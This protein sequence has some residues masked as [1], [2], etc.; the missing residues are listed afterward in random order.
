MKEVLIVSADDILLYQPTLLNLYDYLS[1]TFA[2]RIISFEPEFLGTQKEESRNIIYLSTTKWKKRILRYAELIINAPLKR[3]DKYLFKLPFRVQYV[4]NYKFHLL[5]KELKKHH[6]DQVISVDFM[7]LVAVQKIL[8]NAHLLSLEILSYDP[9][10]KRAEVPK[11]KSLL[12]QN[13]LR[14]NYLFPKEK[15]RVFYIQNSPSC[16]NSHFN[17]G[18]REGLVWGG[19]IAKMFGVFHCIEFIKTNP[20]FSLVLKGGAPANVL[21]EI[22]SA[23]GDLI[24]SSKLVIN[25]QYLSAFEYIKFLSG[26]RIGFCF[27][28]WNI[29]RDN[30]NYQTAPSGKLFMYLAAGLPVVACKIPGFQFV[31]EY[32]AGVLI[33]DYKPET[34]AAAIKVI[35]ADYSSF[36]QNCYKAFS[37]FC[38]EKNAVALK[39]FLTAG[40]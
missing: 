17:N 37:D 6:P 33:N 39:S 19:T 8:G 34:I 38:F 20:Q 32:G 9:Y 25:T 4:R 26:F 36:Q 30:I 24:D 18:E 1:D 31:E 27:Y 10:V 29:I 40:G 7:P 11:I 16:A 28:E 22:R 21:D 23:Y 12:I 35:E 13:E 3:I 5:C 15:P 2:V 14:L